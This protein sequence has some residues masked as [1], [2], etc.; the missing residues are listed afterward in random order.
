V[1][2][3]PIPSLCL[4]DP[5]LACVPSLRATKINRQAGIMS[6]GTDTTAPTRASVPGQAC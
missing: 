1:A 2:L 6:T 5:V 4:E 3:S